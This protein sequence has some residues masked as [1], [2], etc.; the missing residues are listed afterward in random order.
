MPISSDPVLLRGNF[1]PFICSSLKRLKLTMTY[2]VSFDGQDIVDFRE[3]SVFACPNTFIKIPLH[4]KILKSINKSRCIKTNGRKEL[5]PKRLCSVLAWTWHSSTNKSF[6]WCRMQNL[7]GSRLST[8]LRALPSAI[9]IYF[10]IWNG[11][12]IDICAM[13]LR[14]SVIGLASPLWIRKMERGLPR[15]LCCVR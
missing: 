9:H 10:T 14:V 15:R 3:M 4:T 1:L 11:E 6:G 8:A 13:R 7:S 2:S 12:A 5:V